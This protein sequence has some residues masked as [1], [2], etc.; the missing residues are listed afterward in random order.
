MMNQTDT[1]PFLKGHWACRVYDGE[2]ERRPLSQEQRRENVRSIER[3]RQIDT[4][5]GG[6]GGI[7]L[8]VHAGE[9]VSRPIEVFEGDNLITTNG[10][11][12]L[13]DRLFALGTPPTQVNS[14]GVGA[15]A[16][17]AAITDTQIGSTPTIQAFDAL[18]TRASL[19]V[20]CIATFATGAA[21]IS[22]NEIGM[23]NGTV[24]GTSILFNHIAPIGPFAKTSAVS[25]QA[26][27][28]ITQ[29]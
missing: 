24:N 15:T 1:I 2:V 3:Q 7:Y 26:S 12:L 6:L 20:T 19:V 29:A 14:M 13:L 16:T 5:I 27:V 25:I 17:A 10:K 11:G 8:P 22:W 23:L 4:L 28:T 9:I 18:P 21:N